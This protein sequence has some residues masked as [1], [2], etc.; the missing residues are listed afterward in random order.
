MNNKYK[1]ELHIP[2][3]F[4]PHSIPRLSDEART[5]VRERDSLRSSH[6]T[7]PRLGNLEQQVSSAILESNRLAY[8]TSVEDNSLGQ[9]SSKYWAWLQKL[10]GTK[11]PD[12][13]NQPITFGTHTYTDHRSIATSFCRTFTSPLPHDH[14]PDARR[15]R[16][17]ITRSH[18]LNPNAFAFTPDQVA[19]AIRAGGNSTAAGPDG[20]TIRHLKHLGPRGLTYL[21]HLINHSL[22]SSRIP[23]IWKH[24]H[25]IPIPKPDKSRKLF[26]SYR[27]I[28]LLC[29]AAKVL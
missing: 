3:G 5:L 12:T 25:I 4:V 21:T 17:Y 14:N 22:N 6:P 26:S 28:S 8:V 9:D 20:L 10:S 11:S 19:K 16:R 2:Q 13:P 29:P 1:N 24:A 7:H 23:A 15:V 18:P 27:P